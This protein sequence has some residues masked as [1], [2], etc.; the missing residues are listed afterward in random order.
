MEKK[1]TKSGLIKT[2]E[3]ATKI[4]R[5]KLSDLLVDVRDKIIGTLPLKIQVF[6]HEIKVNNFLKLTQILNPSVHL[7]VKKLIFEPF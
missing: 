3:M 1:K 6:G 7:L 4:K 5:S 2:K